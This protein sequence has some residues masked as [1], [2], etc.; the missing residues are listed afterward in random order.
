LEFAA[1]KNGAE[2][3]SGSIVVVCVGRPGRAQPLPAAL[4][5]ALR[6]SAG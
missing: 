4:K 3:A 6:Q 1:L 5:E 2:A